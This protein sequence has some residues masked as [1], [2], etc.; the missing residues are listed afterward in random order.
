MILMFQAKQILFSL[1][2]SDKLIFS[3]QACGV[4]SE[5]VKALGR[6]EITGRGEGEK[7]KR[8]APMEFGEVE[9]GSD[10]VRRG[11]YNRFLFRK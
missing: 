11:K 6:R 9:D 5:G 4:R 7:G 1:S 10:P 2:D 8:L 3:G